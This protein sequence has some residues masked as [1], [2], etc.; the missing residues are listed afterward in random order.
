MSFLAAAGI[1]ALGGVASSLIGSKAATSAANTQAQA[2]R[3]AAKQ[4]MDMFNMSQANFQ[5]YFNAG[6][7]ATGSLQ[8]L[9][10]IGGG[11]GDLLSSPIFS[12]L[13]GAITPNITT[14]FTNV[15]GGKGAQDWLEKTPGYQ[16]T[17]D[18]GLKS[19]QSALSAQ[20]LGGTDP[21]S[22]LASGSLTKGLSQY[23]TGLASNTFQQQFQNY[24][25]NTQQ[26]LANY[27]QSFNNLYQGL[28]MGTGMLQNLAGLGQSSAA[29]V[30][31]LGLGT[32]NSTSNL[33]T[34]GAAAQAGGTVGSANALTGGIGALGSTAQQYALFNAL[35]GGGM[36]GKQNQ[37]GG[38][39]TDLGLG[40]SG[41]TM[42]PFA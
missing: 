20:G 32:A 19:T 5:P 27:G 39:G 14:D 31:Q 15:F 9:L 2:S 7:A 42:N 40:I 6:G 24:L 12:K 3:D 35:Q 10:G 17:L 13:A 30:G 25:A 34:S 21:K 36:F 22:G 41:S 26:Q 11:A 33:L 16:F 1:S 29:G 28:G 4:Q 23:A 38:W 37:G 8:E 18:Q